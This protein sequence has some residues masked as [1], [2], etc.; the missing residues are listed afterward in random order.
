MSDN[1]TRVG[2]P[3]EALALFDKIPAKDAWSLAAVRGAIDCLQAL[4][5]EG[6][7]RARA[8]EEGKT[9]AEAEAVVQNIRTDGGGAGNSVTA[10][11]RFAI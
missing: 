5:R 2:R 11:R 1:T 7:A 8:E 3:A 4:K 6:E 10:C 9:R